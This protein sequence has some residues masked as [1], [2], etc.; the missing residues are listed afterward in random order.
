MC[1]ICF[2]CFEKFFDAGVNCTSTAPSNSLTIHVAHHLVRSTRSLILALALVNDEPRLDHYE[3]HK[4]RPLFA[5]LPNFCL[6]SFSLP[7]VAHNLS[8]VTKMIL[9]DLVGAN[10]SGGLYMGWVG[11]DAKHRIECQLHGVFPSVWHRAGQRNAP[12]PWRLNHMALEEVNRR[13]L[14]IVY[15]HYCEVVSSRTDSFWK[16]SCVMWKM[17]H[18]ILILTVLLPT[19]LRGFVSRVHRA[20]C[21]L[22]E[23]LRKLDGQVYCLKTAIL[24]G[25]EPGSRAGVCSSCT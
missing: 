18:K 9:R 13:A 5:A 3:G 22:A 11:K 20:V 12:L 15:P 19:M 16:K 10:G 4:G 23:A 21:N 6:G 24:L 25:I 2:Y 1:V 14:A 8:N 7:D 17:S